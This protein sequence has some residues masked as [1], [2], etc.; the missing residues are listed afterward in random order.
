MVHSRN[1]KA[2]AGLRLASRANAAGFTLIELAIVG[3]CVTI[4]A[5][6]AVTSYEFATVKARRK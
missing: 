4:L 3:V 5:V 1:A 6:T 2:S